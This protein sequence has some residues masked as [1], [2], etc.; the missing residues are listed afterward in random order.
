MLRRSLPVLAALIAV[1]LPARA[2]V[3]PD[4]EDRIERDLSAPDVATRRTAARELKSMS[5]RRGGPLAVAALADVDD[6]VRLAAA[7]AA[8]R[9]H[10]SAATEVVVAWLN[11]RDPRIRRKACDVARRL[12][13]ASA[14]APLARSLGDPDA[15]VRAAA[16]VALGHQGSADAV[17][18]LL[19]RLDDP[20]PPVRIQIV[21]ALAR[22]GDRRAVV[23]LVSKVED[24]SPD[25]RAGVARALGDLADPRA[26]PALI[27]ALRD[28]VP[29]VRR[30]AMVAMGRMRAGEAVDAL[31]PFLAD[32]TQSL[33]LAAF[34]ALGAIATPDAVR[35]L[36]GTLGKGDDATGG[37]DRTP[38]RSALVTAG[39]AAV[40][41]MRD[42]LRSGS[43]SAA[44]ATSAAWV[45][46]ALHAR[47]EEGTIVD[48]MRSGELPAVAAMRALAGAG[49]DRAVAVVL[50][51][52]GDPASVVRDEAL[53]AALALLDPARADGRAVEPLS[54][55]LRDEHLTQA[56]RVQAVT[57]LGRTG[58]GRAAP[59]LVGFAA[60]NDEPLRIAALD[61]LDSLGPAGSPVADDA[62]LRALDAASPRVRLHGAVALGDVGSARARDALLAKLDG[63]DEVDRS[64][65]LTALTGV[66]A[67]FPSDD[68]SA[69]LVADLALAAGAERDAF[70]EVL[71]VAPH[72]SAVRALSAV[73]S[74]PTAEDRRTA[75]ALLAAHAGDA[76]ALAVARGLLSDRDPATR[77]EAAW[78]LGA[79]GD[80]S[81]VEGLAALL[82]SEDEASAADAAAALGRVAGRTGHAEAAAKWLCPATADGRAFVRVDALAG[83]TAARA[84]CDAG[85]AERAALAQDV[86][87]EVRAAA[88]VAVRQGATDDDR[89]ALARCAGED[90][91]SRVAAL[92]RSPATPSPA[93]PLGTRRTRVYVVPE[94]ADAP[95]P[96]A[97][98]ALLYA[99][100]TLRA[101]V[102]DRRGA[103]VDP[104]APA[105]NLRLTA[106]DR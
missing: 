88:A 74:S 69:R 87:E 25:V 22:L 80:A 54:A 19:G 17:A 96:G 8:V 81:D 13:S 1:A 15:E 9:L 72:P 105:G 56:E 46:G 92:C 5:P 64:A 78:A 100:G 3:W 2:L 14:V 36:A 85:A 98:Y 23:P 97:P 76:G 65:V 35:L 34:E 32:R 62:L 24:S 40:P 75:A 103:V 63:S 70:I 51:F 28:S 66:V 16:A 55:V 106:P 11:A 79:I 95:R 101:G 29:D 21:D 77:G 38:A 20:A 45:L 71:G 47:S 27:L 7:D 57:L 89:R 86:S 99:D 104:V 102:A 83:L 6:D 49:S 58:A 31:A 44:V 39:S 41:A 61:A 48:A 68:A 93:S 33:R 12:P 91:S 26:S 52:V 73:A 82:R 4:V 84:R 37:L 53:A 67:R 50:E 10:A 42:V 43:A 90:P 60:S 59:L 94:A 30:E 18:P